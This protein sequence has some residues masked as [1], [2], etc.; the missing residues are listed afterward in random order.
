MV[1]FS[2]FFVFVIIINLLLKFR[3]IEVILGSYLDLEAALSLKLYFGSFGCGSIYY[4]CESFSHFDFRFFYLLNSSLEKIELLVQILFIGNNIRLEAPLINA[5][6]RK[7]F[8]LNNEFQAYSLGLS[9][10]FLSYPVYNLGNSVFSL[11]SFLEGRLLA[12]R[13]FLL[14][15]FYNLF[16]FGFYSTVVSIFISSAV[17]KRADATDIFFSLLFFCKH[18]RSFPVNVSVINNHIGRLTFAELGLFSCKKNIIR[19]LVQKLIF[20]CGV[21]LEFCNLFKSDFI[22]YQGFFFSLK[23]QVNIILPVPNYTEVSLSYLN[24]EGRYRRTG[25]A[26]VP[27]NH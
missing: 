17:F 25:L 15:D 22:I 5:R 2:W 8:L 11:F 7:A 9:V 10:S 21:D 20:L 1:K 27:M 3:K 14:N 24:L 19:K 12:L 4:C 18:S 13:T 6:F 26:V 23:A 16:K